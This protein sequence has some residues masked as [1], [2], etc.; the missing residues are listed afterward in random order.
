MK[1]GYQ[2]NEGRSPFPYLLD[3]YPNTANSILILEFTRAQERSWQIGYDLDLARFGLPG[4]N[5]FTLYVRGDNYTVGGH[6][7]NEWERD[8]GLSYVVQSGPVKGLGVRWRNAMV[9]SDTS[10]G[11]IDENRLILSYTLPLR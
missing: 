1:F 4:L 11:D 5:F 10:I 7:G 2:A 8:I 3:S 9:R 6:N